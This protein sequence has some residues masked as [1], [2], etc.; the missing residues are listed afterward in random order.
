MSQMLEQAIVDAEALKEAALK[1][2]EQAIVEKYSKEVKEAVELLLEQEPPMDPA[3]GMMPPE[4]APGPPPMAPPSAMVDEVPLAATEGEELCPCP[5]KDEKVEISFSQLRRMA[6]QD[7]MDAGLPPAG[8]PM[9][10]EMGGM[11][12]EEAMMMEHELADDELFLVL[13][14]MNMEEDTIEIDEVDPEDLATMAMAAVHSLAVKAGAE[15]LSTTVDTDDDEDEDYND[16]DFEPVD[17]DDDNPFDN[18]A[19]VDDDED[20]D[21]EDEDDEDEDDEDDVLDEDDDEMELNE[22]DLAEILEALTVDVHNVPTG[23]AG[24]ASNHA[25]DEENLDILN[26]QL[27]NE[28][29]T[30]PSNLTPGVG[31]NLE[32][33]ITQENDNL[34]ESL[35]KYDKHFKNLNE[36]NKQYESLLVK[37]KNRLEEV[38]LTNAKLLYTNRTLNSTSLNERQK[39]KIADAISKVQSVEEA[40]VV[41]ETLQSTVRSTKKTRGPESL[42]EVVRRPS[43]ILPRKQNVAKPSDPISDRWKILAGIK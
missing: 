32:T 31:A 9:G 2:A 27:E 34:K 38:N 39:N 12:P 7:Q 26:A 8:A 23:Q 35:Q 11:P 1:N 18:T 41:Y 33:Q 6:G 40:K 22:S 3:A 16:M 5:E 10:P 30:T 15:D 42:S 14:D 19:T 17:D 24:G 37:L 29:E 21:D 25:L 4:M 43:T 28:S 20:E 36:K 13:E